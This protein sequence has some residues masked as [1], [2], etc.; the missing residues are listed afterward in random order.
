MTP[1]LTHFALALVKETFWKLRKVLE[2]KNKELLAIQHFVSVWYMLL[3]GS[4]CR[5]LSPTDECQET[6]KKNGNRTLLLESERLLKFF[7]H[8][9]ESLEK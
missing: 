2:M 7:V 4:E 8:I 9:M 6:L 3:Y 5:T 1:I